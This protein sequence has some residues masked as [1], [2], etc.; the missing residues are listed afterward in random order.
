MAIDT[1]SRRQSALQSNDF[2]SAGTISPDGGIADAD[3][4]ALLWGYTGIEW[5]AY[6]PVVRVETLYAPIEK[7]TIIDAAINKTETL[8]GSITKT[9]TLKGY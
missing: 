9:I 7:T 1:L 3:G 6:I 5:S 8:Y 4:Q 2:F